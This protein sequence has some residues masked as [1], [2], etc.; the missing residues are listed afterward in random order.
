MNT[1][2]KAAALAV[3]LIGGL[4]MAQAAYAHETGGK[5]GTPMGPNMMDQGGM[6]GMMGMMGQMNEMMA[7]CN[8]MMKGK[9]ATPEH[10]PQKDGTKMP[11]KKG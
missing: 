4:A 6:K 8:Q 1:K 2:V 10:T 5:D 7:N 3:S 11:E 9:T